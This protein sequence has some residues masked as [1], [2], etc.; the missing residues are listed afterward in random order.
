MEEDVIDNEGCGKKSSKSA[1][2]SRTAISSARH[3]FSCRL[4]YVVYITDRRDLTS[5]LMKICPSLMVPITIMRF[6][7]PGLGGSVGDRG[8]R[9]GGR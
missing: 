7:G 3:L 4:K 1:S 8:R 6:R 9:A 2:L 5:H